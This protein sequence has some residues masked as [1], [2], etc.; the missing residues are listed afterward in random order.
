MVKHVAN[1]SGRD[2]KSIFTNQYAATSQS[3]EIT[4]NVIP[5]IFFKYDIEP[6]LLIVSEQRGSFLALVVR[7]VNVMAGVVVGG[8]W[9][10]QL[11][12]WGSEVYGRRRRGGSMGIGGGGSRWEVG[13][14]EIC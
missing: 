3:R 10:F 11:T 9:M 12:E 6:I 4:A 7:L 5:G 1:K 2:S 13:M 14:S 8:G